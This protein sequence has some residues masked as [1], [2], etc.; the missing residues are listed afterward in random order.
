MGWS[1]RIGRIAGIDIY[2]HF[3]FVLLLAWVA[4]RHYAVHRNPL[5]A[6]AGVQSS[7]RPLGSP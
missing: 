1:S 3:T 4:L 2:V 6:V 7:W 5:E